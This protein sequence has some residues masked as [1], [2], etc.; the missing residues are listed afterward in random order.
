MKEQEE[1]SHEQDQTSKAHLVLLMQM[2]Y[3][4]QEAK[5]QV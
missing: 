2:G 1:R 5:A 3:S 4:W